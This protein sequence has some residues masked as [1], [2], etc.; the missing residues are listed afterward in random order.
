MTVFSS[1]TIRKA[2]KYLSS[3]LLIVLFAAGSLA[4]QR[5]A[6]STVKRPSD[7]QITSAVKTQLSNIDGLKKADRIE[8]STH[9]GVV[10]LKGETENLLIR[11]QATEVA[12]N[13]KGVRSIINNLTV[14][15]SRPD[16]AI[17]MDVDNALSTDPA[18]EDMEI[19]TTVKN[20]LVTMKGVA[21]SWQESQ[22]A[23]KI[24]KSVKGVTA[25]QNNLIVHY[26]T[27]RRSRDI[28]TEVK[29]MLRWDAR[30]DDAEIN[31]DVA[32]DNVVKLSGKVGNAYQKD[33]AMQ[34]A[35]VRGVKE[36]QAQQLEV[37]P[38]ITNA[39]RREQM[40]ENINDGQIASAI[41]DAMTYD[42]RV[43]AKDVQ[44]KVEEG[45]ATLSGTVFNLNEKLAAGQDAQNTMG[46]K[47]VSNTISVERR[48]VVR[49]AVP[50]T[51]KAIAGRIKAVFARDPYV[52]P[53]HIDVK[54]NKGVVSLTGTARTGFLKNHYRKLA[55]NVKGV[56][57]V[58]S[59]ITVSS[60]GNNNG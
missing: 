36:V 27:D 18:T 43:T 46:V 14:S 44:V 2:H 54:V 39:M 34:V 4:C 56:I 42:P 22:L 28:A 10:T 7:D 12:E 13:V 60:T 52:S 29:H 6:E 59:D 38:S 45:I 20:G 35:H 58:H 1:G 24:V 53:A 48:V 16:S 49:P 30:L 55:S 57:A 33:L 25:V 21:S 15:A 47:K 37:E 41:K 51:D 23:G 9:N 40:N 5:G 3:L 32:D 17:E 50:T 26:N 11:E 8:I 19:S 31:V